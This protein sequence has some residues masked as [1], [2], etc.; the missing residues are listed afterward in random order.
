MMNPMT[1]AA[2][3]VPNSN[4]AFR[5]S[6]PRVEV[7]SDFESLVSAKPVWDR[8]VDLAGIDHPFLSHDWILSWWESFGAGRQLNILL[9]K[10]GEDLIGIAP[11]MVSRR[12]MYGI[13]VRE[14]GFIYND[15]TPR[16]DF[17]VARDHASVYEAVWRHLLDRR[18]EWDLLKLCQIDS[19]S[20]TLLELPLL[21]AASGCQVGTWPS[22][23]SPYLRIEKSFEQYFKSLNTGLRQN[24]KRRMK[25][26]EERGAVEFECVSA[27]EQIDSALPDAFRI[28]ASSWKHSAGTAID[29]HSELQK[30]YS[31]VA[32][33]AA[34][35]GALYLTFLRVNGLRIAFDLSLIHNNKRFIL[36]P[37]YL[38]EYHSCSPGQQLMAMTIRDAFA[39]GLTEIDFLGAVEAWKLSWTSEKRKNYWLF[40]FQKD[41]RGALLHYTKFRLVPWLQEKQ[42]YVPLRDRMLNLLG[43]FTRRGSFTD[44]A[45]GRAL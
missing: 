17:I 36:K 26:L 32:H 22:I 44:A 37:G 38:Q 12:R 28:E 25:R 41:L 1:L 3:L 18:E 33:R 11:L 24:L 15:H 16:F 20:R 19:G 4:V 29:C 2:P 45:R 9:V 21:A 35:R 31:S 27:E 39:R 42:F 23:E 8:L 13:P 5:V 10:D 7:I 30:F 34:R 14:L 40:V 6:H 43:L